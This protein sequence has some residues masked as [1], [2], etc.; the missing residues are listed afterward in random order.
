[1]GEEFE[2]KKTQVR[3]LV[4]HQ[5][6]EE[7]SYNNGAE[8]SCNDPEEY[9][10]GLFSNLPYQDLRQAHVKSVI[11]VTSDDYNQVQKFENI[12]DY[13]NHRNQ[14]THQ[15]KPLSEQQAME[16]LNKKSQLEENHATKRAYELAKQ[17]ELAQQKNQTFWG[18]LMKIGE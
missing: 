15:L 8:L 18:G 2:K 11:P 3:S 4:V 14:Q 1:M 16:Y 6:I 17:T 5:E 13:T 10:C 12:N 9:S 7:V